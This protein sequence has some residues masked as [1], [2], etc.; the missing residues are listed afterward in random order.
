[1]VVNSGAVSGAFLVLVFC[2]WWSILVLFLV[3]FWCS[4][5]VD[6]GQF[7]CSFWCFFGARVLQMVVISGAPSLDLANYQDVTRP[8]TFLQIA[9]GNEALAFLVLVF[10]RCWSILALF[11]VLFWCSCFVDGGQFWCSFWCF[12][13][14]RVL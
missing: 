10:C 7:W 8:P 4:C 6:G 13:G 2:R 11:L 5:F 14:A 1:M 3:L 12:F 9:L